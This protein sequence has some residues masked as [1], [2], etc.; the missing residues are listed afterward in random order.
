[1]KVGGAAQFGETNF[2]GPV[3]FRSVSIEELVIQ[4]AHFNEKSTPVS[5]TDAKVGTLRVAVYDVTYKRAFGGQPKVD[6][7]TFQRIH[8]TRGEVSYFCEGSQFS[9]DFYSEAEA[10]LRKSGETGKADEL[11]IALKRRER[12]ERLWGFAWLSNYFLDVLVAYGRKPQRAL[13]YGLCI[14]ALGCFVFRSQRGMTPRKEKEGSNSYN[15]FWY[16]LDLF[17]PVI[18]LQAASNWMPEKSRW[19][20]RNYMHVQRILGWILVPIGIAAWTGIIK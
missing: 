13:Y 16:S 17:A 3:G 18:D 12:K 1:M 5:F 10:Y 11:F 7:M 8:V 14:V 9:P 19:F 2:D 6:G 15:A 4:D 20:A